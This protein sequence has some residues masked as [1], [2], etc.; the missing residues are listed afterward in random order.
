METKMSFIPY[1]DS[2]KEAC[3]TGWGCGY[4][5]IPKGHPILVKLI[6]DADPGWTFYL[7]PEGAEQEIT[8]SSWDKAEEFY[9][10]GFDTAHSYNDASNDEAWVIAE[11]EK[12]KALV[13]AYTEED[14]KR[15]AKRHTER[16][17][18]DIDEALLKM[19]IDYRDFLNE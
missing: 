7:Q 9:I 2:F 6:T 17:I 11:T 10:I 19:G 4:V 1:E 3:H 16:V 8:L 14:A 5:H 15:D 13:D 12:I 18:K